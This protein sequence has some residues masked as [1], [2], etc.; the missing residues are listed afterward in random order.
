MDANQW[1]IHDEL[2]ARFSKILL[3]L[4]FPDV[5]S[6]PPLGEGQQ[7]DMIRAYLHSD[8]IAYNALRALVH[9]AVDSL[10]SQPKK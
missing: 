8:P 6:D 10:T 1:R 4:K 9:A 7:K 3:A 5:L 2:T